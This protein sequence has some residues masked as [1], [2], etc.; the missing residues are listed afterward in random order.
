MAYD[1][2]NGAGT[3]ESILSS[4]SM[5]ELIRASFE[6]MRLLDEELDAESSGC[7]KLERLTRMLSLRSVAT[8]NKRNDAQSDTSLG[9]WKLGFG[10]C[11]IVFEIAG[12]PT[13]VKL[14]IHKSWGDALEEDY[15]CHRAVFDALKRFPT[16]AF[17]NVGVRVP[18]PYQYLDETCAWWS[19][20]N[21]QK[22]EEAGLPKSIALPTAGLLSER[23][24]PIP[25]FGR[26]CLIDMFC[27]PERS[28]AAKRD[29]LNKDCLLR[30]YLGRHQSD[31]GRAP[32]FSLRNFNLHVN[33]MRQLNL[34]VHEYARDVGE[35]LAILHWAAHINAYDVEFVMGSEPW[36]VSGRDGDAGDPGQRGIFDTPD[37]KAGVEYFSKRLTRIWVLDFNLCTRLPME[38]LEEPGVADSILAMLVLGFFEN[39][40]Y[41]PL[42]LAEDPGDQRLWDEFQATYLGMAKRILGGESSKWAMWANEKKLPE[43]FIDMCVERE[44]KNLGDGKGHGYREEKQTFDEVIAL[45]CDIEASFPTESLGGDRWYLVAVATLTYASDPETIAHLYTHL[46][47]QP[48]YSTSASRQA[49]IRRIREALLKL[50]GLMGDTKPMAAVFKIADVEREEDRD[51]SF[52]REGWQADQATL[53]RAKDWMS[54]IYQSDMSNIDQKFV[55][56][57]DFGFMAWNILYGFYLSDHTILDAIDTEIVTACNVLIQN[58][59]FGA[60]FHFKGMRKLGISIDDIEAIQACCRKIASFGGVRIDQIP[61]AAD[62][63]YDPT[64]LVIANDFLEVICVV[65]VVAVVVVV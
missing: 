29:P 27:P 44:K 48:S 8:T 63:D 62:I 5:Q 23:I 11:G 45:F 9:W 1:W 12:T 37:L 39:D 18:E 54:R 20:E 6:Q 31:F 43:R 41:Y 2:R 32:N 14:R 35:A 30:V 46:I 16:G 64:T 58:Y 65:T 52:S 21:I 40:P 36:Y 15:Q 42:P 26:E 51:Y 4:A 24:L 47:N 28:Q 10:Q 7:Q 33:Q 60:V 59:G 34:P 49:L 13:V 56:H 53:T 25:K 55:A 17:D 61:P 57:K 22:L 50:T 19:F 38:R 3:N